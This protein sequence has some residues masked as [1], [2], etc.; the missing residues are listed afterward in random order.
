MV[1]KPLIFALAL[2]VLCAGCITKDVSPNQF[3][4]TL[5]SYDMREDITKTITAQQ[6]MHQPDCGN[7]DITNAQVVGSHHLTIMEEWV[8]MACGSEVIYDIQITQQENTNLPRQFNVTRRK[9]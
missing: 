9:E 7:F 1:I 2:T 4:N 3:P 8:V 6:R 5:A